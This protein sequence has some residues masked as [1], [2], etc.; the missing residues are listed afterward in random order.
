M[1]IDRPW[2]T[3]GDEEVNLFQADPREV[4]E[5]GYIKVGPKNNVEL[6]VSDIPVQ[7]FIDM[8]RYLRERG[9]VNDDITVMRRWYD[10]NQQRK[11]GR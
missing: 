1:R 10:F 3:G 8:K 9:Q 6:R 5:H 2:Y 4:A 7:D 11:K